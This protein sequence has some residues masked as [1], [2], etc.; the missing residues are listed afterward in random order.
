MDN[1]RQWNAQEAVLC[2]RKTMI[3]VCQE[4][5]EDGRKLGASK[6]IVYRLKLNVVA[7]TLAGHASFALGDHHHRVELKVI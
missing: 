1:Q 5:E 2:R 3:L 7:L 6:S 4:K